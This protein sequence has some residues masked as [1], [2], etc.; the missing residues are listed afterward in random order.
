MSRT[1]QPAVEREY[2]NVTADITLTPG[3]VGRTFG[4]VGATGTVVITIPSAANCPLGGD[5]KFLSCA[6]QTLTISGTA[7]EIIALNDVAANSV[8]LG[9][10]SEKASGGFVLTAVGP[11]TAA[12]K[13]HVA[14]Q[15]EETQTVTVVS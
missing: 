8:S 2:H 9:T 1:R 11:A 15:T 4:N 6:D 3:D 14:Y 7:G 5:L 13:W 10:S 12:T